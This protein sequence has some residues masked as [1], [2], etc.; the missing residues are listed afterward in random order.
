MQKVH[1]ESTDNIG[2][3]RGQ[4]LCVTMY[5]LMMPSKSDMDQAIEESD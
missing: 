3:I 2:A 5:M 1:R 4:L